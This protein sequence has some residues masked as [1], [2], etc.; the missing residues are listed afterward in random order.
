[1]KSIFD[2]DVRHVGKTPP[3]DVDTQSPYQRED[4]A[5][6][7]GVETQ[8]T[9]GD[10]CSCS[11]GPPKVLTVSKRLGWASV[12]FGIRGYLWGDCQGEPCRAELS[13]NVLG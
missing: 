13:R 9:F 6:R 7:N 8:F 3:W 11:G 10:E 5:V 1:M 4:W 12:S 2:V